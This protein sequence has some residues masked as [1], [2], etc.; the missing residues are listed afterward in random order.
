MALMK[1]N[2][3]ATVLRLTKQSVNRLILAGTIPAYRIGGQWRVR[4]DDLR[5]Y[6]DNAK[7]GKSENV[8]AA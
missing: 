1:L 2:E 4:Q 5:T 8:S 7:S 3:V 6:L